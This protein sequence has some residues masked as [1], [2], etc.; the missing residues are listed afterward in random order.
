LG[1]NEEY[2]IWTAVFVAKEMIVRIFGRLTAGQSE[3]AAASVAAALIAFL[4]VATSVLV[5]LAILPTLSGFG[6]V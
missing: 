6:T 1:P 2:E 4:G 5:S 3:T